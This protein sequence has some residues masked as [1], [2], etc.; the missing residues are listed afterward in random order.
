MSAVKPHFGPV[1][2]PNNEKV[3]IEGKNFVCPNGDCSKV[4]VRFGG[5]KDEVS[6]YVPGEVIDETHISCSVPKFTKPDVLEVEVSV[7]GYDY[8]HNHQTYGFF[9]AY[10]LDVQPRLLSKNG[11]TPMKL[12]GFGFVNTGSEELKSKFSTKGL[13]E[14]SCGS[15][16]CI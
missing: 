11:G 7:D 4:L 9:D 15:S 16:P 2:S 3:I 10:L 12:S 8:T 5:P 6:I 1:K 13:G 14:L